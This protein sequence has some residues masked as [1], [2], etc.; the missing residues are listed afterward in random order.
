MSVA[1]LTEEYFLPLMKLMFRGRNRI[2]K[3][4]FQILIKCCKEEN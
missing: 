3:K 1:S 2:N 4:E